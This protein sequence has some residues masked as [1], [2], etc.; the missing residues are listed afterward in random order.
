MLVHINLQLNAQGDVMSVNLVDFSYFHEIS[1]GR[2]LVY[3]A[4]FS[5]KYSMI[6]IYGWHQKF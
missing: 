2:R 6:S 4:D 5:L 1:S 3:E